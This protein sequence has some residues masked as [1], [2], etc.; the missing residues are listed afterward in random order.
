MFNFHFLDSVLVWA[1]NA[2]ITKHCFVKNR[3]GRQAMQLWSDDTVRF[4][5]NMNRQ[6]PNMQSALDQ[7]MVAA[8]TFYTTDANHYIDSDRHPECAYWFHDTSRGFGNILVG[9][10]AG[11]NT[12]QDANAY[13]IAAHPRFQ[14]ACPT[15]A[16][17]KPRYVK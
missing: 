8:F 6:R 1:E 5:R 13:M 15:C 17:H 3:K 4:N 16:R 7:F 2:L 10:S 9:M 14:K 12:A 11:K